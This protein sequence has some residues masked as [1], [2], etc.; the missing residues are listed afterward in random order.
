MKSHTPDSPS[1][2]DSSTVRRREQAQ[3]SPNATPALLKKSV[4]RAPGPSALVALA[5]KIQG[6]RERRDVFLGMT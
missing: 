2:E 1:E 3:N 5:K 4:D 6:V